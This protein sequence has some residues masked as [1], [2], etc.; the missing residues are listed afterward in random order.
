ML[1]TP[2]QS[3]AT[4]SVVKLCS[5]IY[6]SIAGLLREDLQ[7]SA[8]DEMDYDPPAEGSVLYKLYSLL[9]ILL[10]VRSSVDIAHPRHDKET[11]RVRWTHA[12]TQIQYTFCENVALFAQVEGY[13]YNYHYHCI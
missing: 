9:D 1:K 2:S 4:F 10:M 12:N 8:E 11:F 7:V 5:S 13:H 6:L 3:K